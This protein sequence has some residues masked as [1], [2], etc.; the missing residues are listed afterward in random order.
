[1]ASKLWDFL[2]LPFGHI[3]TK[4]WQHRFAGG[5]VAAVKREVIKIRRHETYFLFKMAEICWGY[6]CGSGKPF[7]D[8]RMRFWHH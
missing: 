5:G 7:L 1:M 4:C 3:M 6:N 8:H 2:F